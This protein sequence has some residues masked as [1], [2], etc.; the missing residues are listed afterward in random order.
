MN[1]A[2]K[3]SARANCRYGDPPVTVKK[4]VPSNAIAP[5]T[6]QKAVTTLEDRLSNI[7]ASPFVWLVTSRSCREYPTSFERAWG[8]SFW[9]FS[10]VLIHPSTR[11]VTSTTFTLTAFSEV[12][13]SPVQHP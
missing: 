8:Y 7:N 9:P 2:K 4:K 13:I 12:R 3:I 5:T 1:I 6:A 10:L 11:K